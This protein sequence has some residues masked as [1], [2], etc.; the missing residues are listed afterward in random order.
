MKSLLQLYAANRP[1]ARS[2]RLV[3]GY[4][5]DYD[6]DMDNPDA[7]DEDAGAEP[8]DEATL[9]VYGAIGHWYDEVQ[10]DAL[11]KQIAGLKAGT[12][13]LRINSPGGDVFEARAIKTALEQSSA[14]VVAHVD[15][16]AASA[17]SFLMLAADEI[18]IA[19]G[20]FV[21]IHNPWGMA[22]GDSTE[23]RATADLL[24]KVRDT[25]AADYKAKTKMSLKDL[26]ALMDAETWMDSDEALA[27]GFVDRLMEKPA[28][29]KNLRVAG[30][31][32]FRNAPAALLAPPEAA[33]DETAA[34]ARAAAA[35]AAASAEQAAAFAALAVDREQ[36]EIRLKLL[37]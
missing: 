4:D 30:L 26:R 1:T 22:I 29:A 19:P 3:A 20:A 9:F 17:A 35:D 28:K 2:F 7:P 32:A 31:K 23:M 6:G 8:V 16:L 25:I 5:P 33:P 11:V 34:A 37:A 14:R 21:M 15:A 24:D 10:A 13:H 18:E 12:I 27:K 36:M